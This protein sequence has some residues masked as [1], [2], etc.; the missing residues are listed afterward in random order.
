MYLLPSI[1]AILSNKEQLLSTEVQCR[2]IKKKSKEGG[3]FVSV[4][5]AGINQYTTSSEQHELTVPQR[6]SAKFTG[7]PGKD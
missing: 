3:F 2:I 1:Q 5:Q 6:E 7:A 4:Q